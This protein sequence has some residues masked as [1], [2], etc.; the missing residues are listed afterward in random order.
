[1]GVSRD[2]MGGRGPDSGIVQE[3]NCRGVD[4]IE[5]PEVTEVVTG[6][7]VTEGFTAVRPAE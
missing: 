6:E 1:M 3:S 2:D 5:S 4:M 7:D